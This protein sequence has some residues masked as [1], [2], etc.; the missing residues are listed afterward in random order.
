[1][2]NWWMRGRCATGIGARSRRTTDFFD[3][4]E[5]WSGAGK[6]YWG[7]AGRDCGASGRGS[8]AVCR[9]DAYGGWRGGGD[10]GDEDWVGRR[11]REVPG[12]AAGGGNGGRGGWGA[13]PDRF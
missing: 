4:R 6:A 2:T 12:K 5:V 13:Q 11:F 1:M 10:S 9:S 8:S 3:V 7:C